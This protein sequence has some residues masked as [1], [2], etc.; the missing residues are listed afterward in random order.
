MSLAS[1]GGHIISL[2][3]ESP[4]RRWRNVGVRELDFIRH[5]EDKVRVADLGKLACL[6]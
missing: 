4:E 6:S 1:G 5:G 2:L 3:S